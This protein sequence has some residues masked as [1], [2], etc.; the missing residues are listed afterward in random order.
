MSFYDRTD[1]GRRLAAEL[2]KF[3]G[4]D[5]VVFALPRGGAP[6]A[7]P[8]AILLKAPLISCSSGK[9]ACPSSRSWRWAPWRMA[10]LR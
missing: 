1:A 6:V 7:E 9:S 8:I 4:E 10:A 3:K 5:V 2:E